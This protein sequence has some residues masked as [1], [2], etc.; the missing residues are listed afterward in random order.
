MGTNESLE[1][2]A[3]GLL[4]GDEDLRRAAAEALANDPEEG[5]AMLRD[6]A[7]LPDILVRRAVVYGLARVNEPWAVELLQKLRVEDQQWVVR[8]SAAEVLE[9]CAETNPRV[10][11]P[12]TVPSETPWIIEFA[13]SQGVG[14]SPGSPATEILIAAIK[15]DDPEIRLAAVPYL[16]RTPGE[17]VI[18]R[19]YDAMYSEDSTLREAVFL[20]LMEIAASDVKLPHPSQ[21]GL[22]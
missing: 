8:N 21:F 12:L 1:I 10:P 14:I 5:H 20:T 9:R 18:R 4:S 16:K 17:G 13:G 7:A 22:G 19:L 6:G 2:V 15:S 11:Q 3:H